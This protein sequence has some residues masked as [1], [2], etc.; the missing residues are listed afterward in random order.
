[1]VAI[2]VVLTVI[3]AVF[4]R[5]TDDP[6]AAVGATTTSSLATASSAT[7]GSSAAAAGPVRPVVVAVE[8]VVGW[9]DG[10]RFVPA[11]RGEI[12]VEGGEVYT[13]VGIGH[14][15]RTARGSTPEGGCP[16]SDPA[17][18]TIDVGIERAVDGVDERP[19]IA[20]TGVRD[21]VPRPVEVLP[22]HPTYVEAAAEVLEGLHVEDPEPELRQVVRTD[23]EGDGRDEVLLVAE[24]AS[25]PR[26]LLDEPGDHSVVLL[27]Q[28]VDGEVVTTV[29]AE[30]TVDGGA[31]AARA[32]LAVTRIVA[33]ADLNGDGAMELVLQGRHRAGSRTIVHRVDPTGGVEE[34][35]SAGCDA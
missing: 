24:R 23:F 7:D 35:L 13:V 3:T 19:P 26:G 18:V 11:G 12:P 22:S 29:V 15:S 4:A 32:P 31:D 9:W 1:V 8:G 33:V 21:V 14:P 34:L 27:R 16:T 2:A 5:S 17:G 10:T 28:V 30:A 20:V 25:G 6:E